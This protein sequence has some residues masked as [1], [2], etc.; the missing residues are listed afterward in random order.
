MNINKPSLNVS[1]FNIT[2]NPQLVYSNEINKSQNLALRGNIISIAQQIYAQIPEADKQNLEKINLQFNEQ[3]HLAVI[4]KIGEK[5]LKYDLDS[6]GEELKNL[7]KNLAG[8]VNNLG[9][10][11]IKQTAMQLQPKTKL[12]P[13]TGHQTFEKHPIFKAV[14]SEIEDFIAVALIN[15]SDEELREM[16]TN[17]TR[18]L[19]SVKVKIHNFYSSKDDTELQE[20]FNKVFVESVNFKYET[21]QFPQWNEDDIKKLNADQWLNKLSSGSISLKDALNKY[22]KIDPSKIDLKKLAEIPIT[23]ENRTDLTALWKQ[24]FNDLFTQGNLQQLQPQINGSKEI[25][26]YNHAVQFLNA[27]EIAPKSVKEELQSFLEPFVSNVKSIETFVVF[28]HRHVSS[29]TKIE[30]VNNDLKELSNRYQDAIHIKFNSFLFP[31][32]LIDI[33]DTESVIR[34]LAY[35]EIV[36]SEI[37]LGIDFII[38]ELGLQNN[39]KEPK[40]DLLKKVKDLF[41]LEVEKIA[42]N[43]FHLTNLQIQSFRESRKNE[44][45]LNKELAEPIDNNDLIFF[46]ENKDVYI[47][48]KNKIIEEAKKSSEQ[49]T[50]KDHLLKIEKEKNI[51]LD[52][53][54]QHFCNSVFMPSTTSSAAPKLIRLTPELLLTFSKYKFDKRLEEQLWK[55]CLNRI[56]KESKIAKLD[57][58]TPV[59]PQ[60]KEQLKKY[61]HAKAMVEKL[62]DMLSMQHELRSYIDELES[63]LEQNKIR[64]YLFNVEKAPCGDLNAIMFN[65]NVVEDI[66]RSSEKPI[67][68]FTNAEQSDL[69]FLTRIF[70]KSNKTPPEIRTEQE[71]KELQLIF[72][73]IKANPQI[74]KKLV[75][76]DP[77]MTPTQIR[78]VLNRFPVFAQKLAARFIFT[79]INIPME[80]RKL[81]AGISFEVVQFLNLYTAT[82]KNVDKTNAAIDKVIMKAENLKTLF[83][84]SPEKIKTEDKLTL[85]EVGI[86]NESARLTKKVYGNLNY[87]DKLKDLVPFLSDNSTAKMTENSTK[88]HQLVTFLETTLGPEIDKHYTDGSLL[89]YVGKKKSAWAGKPLEFEERMTTYIGGLI[90]GAKLFHKGDTLMISHVYGSYLQDPVSLYQICI[91]DIW[92]LDISTLVDPAMQKALQ[93]VYGE[94]WKT[95]VNKQYQETEKTLHSKG[96]RKFN[97]IENDPE[98]RA[99]AGLAR[100]APILNLGIAQIAGMKKF[101]GH[102]SVTGEDFN[103]LRDKFFNDKPLNE[104]Q[105]CSEFATKTTLVSI[106]ELNKNLAKVLREKSEKYSPTKILEKNP[107]AF[108]A[109]LK[110]YLEGHTIVDKDKA[111]IEKQLK[112]ILKGLK[113]TSDEIEVIMKISRNNILDLPYNEKENLDTVHPSHMI[114]LLNR[115]KCVVKKTPPK[116]FTTL[117]NIA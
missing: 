56:F 41:F 109:P 30:I 10:V 47:D 52:K 68:I 32:K 54:A 89:A 40:K 92:E 112:E 116:A 43:N 8:I 18:M 22:S 69:M 84:N 20:T 48:Q 33:E 73:R 53:L 28:Q 62:N 9:L 100:F 34:I 51:A 90:H 75:F 103:L 93:E 86:L 38:Q 71:N 61:I 19:N 88:S 39:T 15:K 49:I 70:N 55:E 1:V 113:Y 11:A 60:I 64:K 2:N 6:L 45:L 23:D 3:N 95:V 87:M 102:T 98:K 21:Q 76:F 94:S 77:S 50:D 46:F 27:L 31:M 96:Y 63:S 35:N 5:E 13:D 72:G 117:L 114:G 106:L 12:Q 25:E 67:S 91:S 26:Q 110:K 82:V 81:P 97:Q 17:P 79:D 85:R 29:K 44:A 65:N 42:V 111:Q 78:Q 4:V 83:E 36:D 37:D 14:K 74:I 99:R 57:P 107:D 7:G 115:K 108:S 16:Y 59:T 104:I 105:I 58:F 24:I 66:R 80:M 101:K